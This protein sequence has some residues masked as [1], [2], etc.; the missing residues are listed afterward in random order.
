MGMYLGGD[1]NNYKFNGK[2]MM[3]YDWYNF[4]AR[5]MDPVVGRWWVPDPLAEKY[6]HISPYAYCG[7]QPI[8][9]IDPDGRD[10][11]EDKYG[12]AMW[13]AS[14]DEEYEDDNKNVWRNIG[15]EYL[16]FNGNKL[17]YF[18]QRE[19]EEGG[20]AGLSIYSYDAVSGRAQVDKT[21]SY[22]EENQAQKGSGPIP[23]GLYS[24]NPQ[25]IQR[26]SDLSMANKTASTLGIGGAFR[27]GTYAWGK[28]RVWIEPKSVTVTNPTTGEQ[29][30]RN[31]FSIHGGA[32]P[33]SAG[34]IDLHLNAPAF[35]N[36]LSQ[37]KSS[38]VRLNVLYKPYTNSPLIWRRK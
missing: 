30:V 35:F 6:Y 2:E 37:S 15:T 21:F 13:R 24:I 4:G 8:N 5:I 11:Y 23:E 19:N 34:C 12:N 33:G 7:N 26:Y 14:S 10:W 20:I 16:L 31:D 17:Y 27:G 28:E 18:Q 25:D 9:R 29:V 38:F 32:V 3:L 1:E 36:R 22:T